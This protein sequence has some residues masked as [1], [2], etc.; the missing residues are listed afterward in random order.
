[1]A[2][3]WVREPGPEQEYASPVNKHDIGYKYL[4][5]SKRIFIQLLRS[6]VHQGWVRDMDE[7][8]IMRLDKS[9]ILQDFQGKEADLVYRLS[10]N[11]KDV[12]FYL[13]LELQANGK[14]LH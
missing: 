12:I 4:L 8:T 5:S 14:M 13:L 7:E 6:F 3:N 11:G 1:M 9:F 10:L 2:L